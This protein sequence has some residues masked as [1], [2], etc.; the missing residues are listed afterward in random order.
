MLD[1]LHLYEVILLIL[2]TLLFILAAL[3]LIIQVLRHRDAKVLIPLF[4]I[5]VLMIGFPGIKSISFGDMKT[6]LRNL[7]LRLDTDPGDSLARVKAATLIAR[8]QTRPVKSDDTRRLI[9]R[10]RLVLQEPPPSDS[11]PGSTSAPRPPLRPDLVEIEK[12]TAVITAQPANNTARDRLQL[13]VR[14]SGAIPNLTEPERAIINRA[15]SA[16]KNSRPR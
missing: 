10:V 2:G 12:L 4:A 16:L 9:D 11:L 13:L 3:L 6:E 1:G 8:I 5:A 14:E 15:A 7:S